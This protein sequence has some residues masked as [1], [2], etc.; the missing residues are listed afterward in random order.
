MVDAA[1]VGFAVHSA[2][3]SGGFSFPEEAAPIAGAAA[4]FAVLGF[5]YICV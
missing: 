4:V 5:A 1:E 3:G 2:T